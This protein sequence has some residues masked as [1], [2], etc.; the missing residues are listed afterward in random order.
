M[1]N[2]SINNPLEWLSIDS[3]MTRLG[4]N[5]VIIKKRVFWHWERF[6]IC[7]KYPV[8]GYLIPEMDGDFETWLQRNYQA[9]FEHE[10]WAWHTDEAVWP[11]DRSFK[12]FQTLFKVRFHSV[13]LDMGEGPIDRD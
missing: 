6:P 8:N 5:S 12:A 11:K 9:M 1:G 3:F 4:K 7:S 2:P 10:L 13:V